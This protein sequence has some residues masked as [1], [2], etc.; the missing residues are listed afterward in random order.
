L[1]TSVGVYDSHTVTKKVVSVFVRFRAL[2]M[3]VHHVA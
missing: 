2:S 3:G 1:C